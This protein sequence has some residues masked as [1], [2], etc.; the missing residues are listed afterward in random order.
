MMKHAQR[1]QY[2]LRRLSGVRIASAGL[3]FVMLAHF[4]GCSGS[5]L[6]QSAGHYPEKAP[7]QQ[8]QMPSREAEIALARSAAPPSVSGDADVLVLGAKG[9]DIAVKGKNGFSCIVERAWANDFGVG[10]FWNPK[11]RAPICFNPAA[12][13]TVLPLYL[14]RTKWVLE[15][16]SSDEMA[17]RSKAAVASKTYKPPEPGAMCYMMSKDGY[18]NDEG[19]HWHPHLMYFVPR[20]KDAD[21]G[22]NQPGSPV[23]GSTS[24]FEPWS[25]FMATVSNWSDGSPGPAMKM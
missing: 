8:Y 17:K 12:S 22:A 25:L 19:G 18:L 11:V 3:G 23:I 21:W 5:A 2:P 1:P 14:A 24:E 16:V 20:M 6:A 10:E 4:G 13:R 9:Y 7:M 15:G